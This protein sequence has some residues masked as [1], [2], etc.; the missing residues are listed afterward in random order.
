MPQISVFHGHAQEE[1]H[2]PVSNLK[3]DQTLFIRN[4]FFQLGDTSRYRQ[5][6][7]DDNQHSNQIPAPPLGMGL[8]VASEMGIIS[9]SFWFT[10]HFCDADAGG[11]FWRQGS[12]L[13]QGGDFSLGDSRRHVAMRGREHAHRP[14]S[15]TWVWGTR[16]R[17]ARKLM[18]EEASFGM[19]SVGNGTGKNY[20]CQGKCFWGV[21]E[22]LQDTLSL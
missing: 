4:P 7:I 14:L 10:F 16:R 15:V 17:I 1:R 3:I 18:V 2:V 19:F 12:G 21:R 5:Y 11:M 20:C 9:I 8:H 22:Q 6:F 13:V